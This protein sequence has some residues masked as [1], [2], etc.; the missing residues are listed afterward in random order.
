[1]WRMTSTTSLRMSSKC[2][3]NWKVGAGPGSR[4]QVVAAWCFRPGE[5]SGWD[6]Q[7]LGVRF[8]KCAAAVNLCLSRDTGPGAFWVPAD[9]SEP[10]PAD[11]RRGHR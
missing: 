1:M 8:L 4:G 9:S 6:R 3:R 5:L 10:P 2:W 7:R 11:L